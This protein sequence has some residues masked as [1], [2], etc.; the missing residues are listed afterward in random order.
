VKQVVEIEQGKREALELLETRS[1]R[2]FID[3]RDA[4][5]AYWALVSYTDFEHTSAGKVFNIGSG[6]AHSV[7]D[8]VSRVEEITGRTYVVDLPED[9]PVVPIPF[10]Q[11]DISRIRDVTGWRPEISLKQSLA[12]MI[13]GERGR[14]AG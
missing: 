5:R 9:P 10:Q 4:V 1:Y 3:V 6:A 11:G 13:E 14:M 12:D 7:S 8:V 2:D